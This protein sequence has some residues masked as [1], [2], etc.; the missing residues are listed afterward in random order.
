M[1]TLVSEAGVRLPYMFNVHTD[2]STFV[3]AHTCG[4]G[5]ED[6]V[7]ER[8]PGSRTSREAGGTYRPP[9]WIQLSIANL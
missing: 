6:W 1:A 4:P 2:L 5:K 8:E 9:A 3:L 7:V